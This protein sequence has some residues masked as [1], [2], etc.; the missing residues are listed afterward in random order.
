MADERTHP[1]PDQ[2]EEPID[3]VGA[4][5]VDL[6]E[7]RHGATHTSP[8][9]PEPGHEPD[10]HLV[11]DDHGHD[12][13]VDDHGGDHPTEDP[14]WVIGPL[15]IGVVIGIVLVIVLGLQSGA[16]PFHQL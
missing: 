9:V 13:H 5:N 6:D 8:A 1:R 2:A 15:V 7:A 16:N 3:D 11:H 4:S 12:V 14:K 10:D